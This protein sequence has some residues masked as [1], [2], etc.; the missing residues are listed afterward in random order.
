[1]DK[2]EKYF[3][4]PLEISLWHRK[5]EPKLHA[6]DI[7]HLVHVECN[8]D[9]IPVALIEYK[10][11]LAKPF[12]E[13]KHKNNYRAFK[14]LADM[15]KIPAFEV[16]YNFGCSEFKVECI[17]ELAINKTKGLHQKYGLPMIFKD[18]QYAQLLYWLS[19]LKVPS[20]VDLKSILTH[21][22]DLY[23]NQFKKIRIDPF[24]DPN[25]KYNLLEDN[26]DNVAY[27]EAEKELHDLLGP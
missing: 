27:I 11:F 6:I 19:G 25:F 20:E 17:N 3:V 26:T 21:E 5:L 1:M 23:L 15:A 10:N 24:Q 4:R 8:N 9:C 16:R 14:N 18:F 2:K 12:K 13:L 22:D 7:D